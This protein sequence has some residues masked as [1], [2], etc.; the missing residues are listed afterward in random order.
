VDFRIYRSR[1]VSQKT[2]RKREKLSRKQVAAPEGYCDITKSH[3][4]CALWRDLCDKKK[5]WDSTN[6]SR[7]IVD[8]FT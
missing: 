3:L 8:V 7:R 1:Y 2:E 4:H 5:L 6:W